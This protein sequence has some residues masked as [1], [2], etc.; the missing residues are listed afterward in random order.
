MLKRKFK[1]SRHYIDLSSRRNTVSKY[2][3]NGYSIVEYAR[4]IVKVNKLMIDQIDD[5]MRKFK[6][7]AVQPLRIFAWNHQF[8]HFSSTILQVQKY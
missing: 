2:T 1:E 4:K 3:I 5:S 7:I 6:A 8:I